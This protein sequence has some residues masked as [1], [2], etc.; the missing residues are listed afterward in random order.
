MLSGLEDISRM[1]DN[2][3]TTSCPC[4]E[5]PCPGGLRPIHAYNNFLSCDSCGHIWRRS[6][7]PA[8]YYEPLIN[9]NPLEQADFKR[10]LNERFHTLSQIIRKDQRILEIGCAEGALGALIK[11]KFPITYVGIEPSLD[12]DTASLVL[13]AVYRNQDELFAMRAEPRFDRILTFHVLEHIPD[14]ASEIGGW[15]KLIN[16]DSLVVMEVPN[17]SGHPMVALDQNPEHIH[18]FNLNSL[19]SLLYRSGFA[20]V[21]ATT[22]NFESSVY[23]DSLRVI[24]QLNP[25]KEDRDA[26]LINRLKELF[27]DGFAVYG[28][29]GDFNNYIAR[30]IPLLPEGS[31]K[32]LHDSN[33]ARFGEVVPEAPGLTITAVSES[34]NVPIL[35]SSSR[36]ASSIREQLIRQG[37]S[38]KLLFDFSDLIENSE[39]V[40]CRKIAY[41]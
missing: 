12:A 22:G 28:V 2:D 16:P 11:K 13:D 17:Q 6:M 7:P 40:R 20:I 32:G 39:E 19:S 27:P 21:D 25:S 14:L 4:C 9:R 8:G 34:T 33:K 36:F 3:A 5:D 24:A 31:L 29:G 15:R 37:I 35:I 41:S 10:K 23:P 38:N 18:Q 30:I 1:I 26:K